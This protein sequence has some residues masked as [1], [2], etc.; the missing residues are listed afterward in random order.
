MP[1]RAIE[2]A[3]RIKGAVIKNRNPN[4][5]E[6][7]V[8]KEA[9]GM[10]MRG[11]LP[12]RTRLPTPTLSSHTGVP[13][14]EAISAPARILL[15]ALGLPEAKNWSTVLPASGSERICPFLDRQSQRNRRQDPPRQAR[16]RSKYVSSSLNNL[17]NKLTKL[18]HIT[19]KRNGARENRYLA[20]LALLTL[21]VHPKCKRGDQGRS[22][23][24]QPAFVS[25]TVQPE[26]R[27]LCQESSGPSALRMVIH[28]SSVNQV[29]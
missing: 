12:C 8:P 5:G 13:R 10:G 17:F 7:N 21:P 11:R 22:K 18:R 20:G 16:P 14:P 4:R 27:T 6:V 2:K 28:P 9:V 25:V 15:A 19:P 29:I 1:F 26:P 3:K 24:L 23:S